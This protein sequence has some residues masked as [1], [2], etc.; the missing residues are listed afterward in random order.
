MS[1]IC[2]EPGASIFRIFVKCASIMRR[3]PETLLHGSL[4][5]SDQLLVSGATF[6][7]TAMVARN[8]STALLGEFILAWTI[9]SFVRT[10]QERL[11]L[12][13]FIAFRYRPGYDRKSFKASS[14]G[15]QLVFAAVCC[16]FVGFV[17]LCLWAIGAGSSVRGL[18][19]GLVF[20][21]PNI[22]VRDHLRGMSLAESEFA[23]TLLFDSVV[24]ALQL[25]L[26][27]VLLQ[28][29]TFTP[30]TATL[31]MGAGCIPPVL[32]WYIW[33]FHVFDLSWNVF[34]RD[35][36]SNW[37]YSR[38]LLVA[39]LFGIAPY[40]GIPW[41]LA[42]FIDREATG[43]F[44]NCTSLVGISMTFVV[45]V[46]NM[47]QPKTVRSLHQGGIP[48]M[49]RCLG[50]ACVVF[51]TTLSL[52]STLFYFYGD[53]ALAMIY[54]DDFK[55]YG[56]LVFLLSVSTLAVSFAIV[57]GNGLAAMGN[58]RDYFFGEFVGC[59]AAMSTACLLIPK[60][61]LW[62]AAVALI[63]G[64]IAASL[65][66]AYSLVRNVI[67]YCNEKNASTGQI[68]MHLRSKGI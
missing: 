41:V 64:G 51:L 60:F 40:L 28:T 33:K 54:G 35:W 20:T 27:V 22:L 44:G 10:I 67:S 34:K 3:I 39:R 19:I 65:S 63:A 4:S 16:V 55:N 17:A 38:W 68:T 23:A 50:E 6:A 36:W 5:L 52:L 37:I 14:I 57:I 47:F 26:M 43:I 12:A 42:S 49:L 29:D 30:T 24:V 48:A 56:W 11:I 18:A 46:N 59:V 53:Y 13:P 15:H 32:T 31:A 45:G 2:L 8:C 25:L 66:S 1:Q 61:G 62:G 7:T 58:S 9:V 21:V